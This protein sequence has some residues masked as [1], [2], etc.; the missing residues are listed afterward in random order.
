M[1]SAT[2][3]ELAFVFVLSLSSF[4]SQQ[5]QQPG[6]KLVTILFDASG[7]EPTYLNTEAWA[8]KWR[9]AVGG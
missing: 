2:R 8:P 5:T 4:A 9:N 3:M 1:K 6:R 7:N